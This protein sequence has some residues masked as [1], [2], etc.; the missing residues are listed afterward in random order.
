MLEIL[1]RKGDSHKLLIDIW[2]VK[3]SLESSLVIFNWTH[4]HFL[5]YLTISFLKIYST[6]SKQ[7]LKC[8]CVKIII[9]PIHIVAKRWIQNECPSIGEWLNKL[10]LL[11]TILNSHW[12]SNGFEM[13]CHSVLK[14][15]RFR[16]VYIKK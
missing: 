4:L 3:A 1:W 14:K 8:N 12:M 13:Y 11:C 15:I 10:W 9:E 16:E 5:F 7:L 6:K 2:I